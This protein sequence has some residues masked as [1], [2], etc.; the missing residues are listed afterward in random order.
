M[1]VCVVS[2]GKVKPTEPGERGMM[3]GRLGF[4]KKKMPDYKVAYVTMVSM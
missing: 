1:F 3:V 2:P 4:R